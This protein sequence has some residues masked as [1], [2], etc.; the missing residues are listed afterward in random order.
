MDM[1][2]WTWHDDWIDRKN[3]TVGKGD[4]RI[5]CSGQDRQEWMDRPGWT[6]HD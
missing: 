3:R 6:G 4:K 1:T 2:E 5:G